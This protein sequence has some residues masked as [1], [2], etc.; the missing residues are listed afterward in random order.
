MDDNRLTSSDIE[1]ALSQLIEI[2]GISKPIDKEKILRP[3]NTGNVE[4]LITDIAKYYGLPVKIQLSYVTAGATKGPGFDSTNLVKVK[5]SGSTAGIS[6][7]V[8]IPSNLPLFGTNSLIGFPIEVRIDKI[9]MNQAS[10]FVAVMAH[11][12]AHVLL[13]SIRHP[14]KDDEFYTDL[15]AMILGFCVLMKDGRT[16]SSTKHNYDN[17]TTT[18]HT[19]G[20][21]TESQLSYAFSTIN[22]ILSSRLT[23]QAKLLHNADKLRVGVSTLKELM[24]KVHSY[25]SYV[26]KQQSTKIRS[27]HLSSI[28][29]MHS[30]DFF[31]PFQEVIVKGERTSDNIKSKFTTITHFTT[32]IYQSLKSAEKYLE[33]IQQK[34]NVSRSSL[35]THAKHLSPYVNLKYRMEVFF[36]NRHL[37]SNSS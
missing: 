25:L 14:K 24:G 15:T 22:R 13:H 27:H 37:T 10:S 28:M 36:E 23:E 12:F 20:Y 30:P 5:A 3:I 29:A 19:F 9:L 4:E 17:E 33:D 2:F 31:T 21:L 1:K 16:F 32:S 8:I 35:K 18:T 26:D 6:A 34:L 7:Q 11:E